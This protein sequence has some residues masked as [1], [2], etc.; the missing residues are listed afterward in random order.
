MKLRY[1]CPHIYKV[2]LWGVKRCIFCNQYGNFK[3][4]YRLWY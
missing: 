1:A 4:V 2:D 3:N